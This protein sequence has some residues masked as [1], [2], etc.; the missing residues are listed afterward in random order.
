MGGS[1]VCVMM[2]DADANAV[3]GPPRGT[4]AGVVGPL[5]CVGSGRAGKRTAIGP[6][7]WLRRPTQPPSW[8][9]NMIFAIS[10]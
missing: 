8:P 6:R 7:L 2:V 1:W 10:D 9:S 4:G 5:L 3:H